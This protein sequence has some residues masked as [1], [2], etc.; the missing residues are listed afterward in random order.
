MVSRM[1]ELEG[2]GLSSIFPWCF[3]RNNETDVT[4]VTEFTNMAVLEPTQPMPPIQELDAMFAEVVDELDLTDEKRAAMF[5]LPAEKKWHIYYTRKMKAEGNNGVTC[6]PDH[7]IDQ[8]RSMAARRTLVVLEGEDDDGRH[9]IVEGLKTALRTQPMSF[10]TRFIELDGLSCLLNFLKT[11]DYEV[12]ESQIHTSLI[13]C[14]KA[15]MNN[16]QGRTHVLEHCESIN[17]IAQSLTVENIKTKVAVLEILGAVCLVPG[18]HKKVLDAMV[19]Y[20]TFASERTRFQ[21]LVTDLDRSTGRYRD[22][23]NVKTAIMSFINA[24]LG[25]GAGEKSLEF[26]VHLRYEFLMLGI[27]PVIDKLRSH[28]NA[29]LDRHLD[30]FE[31]IRNE[32]EHL[33]AKRFDREHIETKS[34]SGMFELI[35]KKLSHTEAYPHLLSALQHCLMMPYKP[36]NT[37]VQHWVLLD[38]IIQQMVLQTDKGEDPDMAPLEDFNVKNIVRLLVKEEAVKQWKEQADAMKKEHQN[39]QQRFEKKERECEAK[40]KEKEEMLDMVNKLKEKLERESNDHK[41]AKLQIA[42]LMNQQQQLSSTLNVPGGP[43][44]TS[45]GL[46]PPGNTPSIPAGPGPPTPPP[47]PPPPPPGGAPF[48]PPPPPPPPGAPP[49]AGKRKDIPQPPNPLK[50]FNW[51]KI[52]EN[53]IEG[54][55]WKNIDDLNA[56]K[57]LDL[58]EFQRTF[59]AYQKLQ[60]DTEDDRIVAKKVK[61]LSVIDGRRAQ[62]CNILLSRLKLTNEEIRQA[63]LT[64]DEQEDLPKDMLEQLLKFVPEKSDTELLEEHKHELDRMAKADRFLYDM[65]RIDHYQQR[66]Q[67]LCFK[68]K[69][70]ERVA[71]IK[72]KIKA[73]SLASKEVVQSQKLRQLLEVV[74]AFGNYMNKGQRGNAYG[75]K[76]SSINKIADTK[77]SIDKNVTLLHYLVTVLEKKYPDV[78][79]FSEELQNVPEASKVNM[80]ELEKDISSLRS[81]LKSVEAELQYQ[82]AQASRGP[83]DRFIP[84]VSE[85][86]IVASFSFSEVEESLTEAKD[87]FGKALRHFGEEPSKI[88]PDE[89][90]GIFGGFFTAFSEAKQENA[91]MARRKEEEERRA[92]LEAQLKKEREQRVKAKADEEEGGEFDE[93]V[94]ALRSGEVFEKDLSKINHK[95]Q[96][97]SHLIE[98]NRERPVSKLNE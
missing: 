36:S 45:G 85:F 46:V 28:E 21:K 77:S 20:Q 42:E 94:S 89:F 32:D 80:A 44:L 60:K 70:A 54:T 19:H 27:Q 59:S 31:I 53:K 8:L 62:N 57:V 90:F 26:R 47:P 86:I 87:M 76:L 30:F 41:Q 75:F 24:V 52:P 34:A 74:L 39:L 88:Q 10:V 78:A 92:L 33:M 1:K 63:V 12:A 79:A 66:L 61:E 71:D 38:R 37:T 13:G 81:G 15:L 50:S 55:I 56:F 72:P 97:R 68:K 14:I 22:E 91:I 23:V 6:W 49:G 43:P 73:L 98:D 3:K 96:R 95:K 82:Q 16:S 64:M 7:Y 17:I 25:K 84:M 58:E 93:L 67:S 5:D 65:S 83:K 29:T 18:G 4:N 51:S 69:F 48:A 9:K 40:I 2:W 35:R 11:M